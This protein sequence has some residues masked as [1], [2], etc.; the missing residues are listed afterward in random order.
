MGRKERERKERRKEARFKADLD[1]ALRVIGDSTEF[2]ERILDNLRQMPEIS[3][4]ML[5]MAEKNWGEF[6]ITPTRPMLVATLILY[7]IN[8]LMK[9]EKLKNEKPPK[10]WEDFAAGV[11][12]MASS[13]NAGELEPMGKADQLFEKLHSEVLNQ[14]R[15]L[16]YV[17]AETEFAKIA[18]GKMRR[19]PS[20]FILLDETYDELKSGRW[21]RATRGM[22]MPFLL[23]GANFARRLYREIYPLTQK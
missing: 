11:R 16:G 3:E 12:F 19:D 23:R 21:E 20:G 8:P 13:I 5:K 15:T 22:M 4:E 7:M 14:E 10:V 17:V 1:N 9:M 18:S 6:G 2:E